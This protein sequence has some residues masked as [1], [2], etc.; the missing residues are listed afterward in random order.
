MQIRKREQGAAA[1]EFAVLFPIFFLIFYAIVTYGLIF[2][3]QQTVTLAAAEGARA[4]V[5]YQAGKDQD[6]RKVARIAA[7][8][9]M[10]NQVLAWMRKTGTGQATPASGVCATGITKTEISTVTAQ[11]SALSGVTCIKVLVT[12]DYDQ[13]PLIPKLLGPL[14]SLPTPKALQGQAVAQ[15]SLV[16]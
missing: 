11:C 15:I 13:A 14:L 10:S 4:A 5:R 7:A 2:A 16:D 3:A 1:I 8:C 9:D 6:A 12:Y